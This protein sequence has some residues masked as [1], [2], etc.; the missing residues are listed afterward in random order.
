MSDLPDSL[1]EK[2][3]IGLM[4][5]YIKTESGRFA[6]TLEI[7]SVDIRKIPHYQRKQIVQSQLEFYQLLFVVAQW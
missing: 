6:D 7:S 2:Y 3:D 1:I 4:Y 5:L